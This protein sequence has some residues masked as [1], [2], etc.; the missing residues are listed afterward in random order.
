MQEQLDEV[1]QAVEGPL[2]VETISAV[3]GAISAAAAAVSSAFESLQSL[4]GGDELRNAFESSG[5]CDSFQEQ[6]DEIRP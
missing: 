4:D 3:T 1:E 2:G 6:L 5:D